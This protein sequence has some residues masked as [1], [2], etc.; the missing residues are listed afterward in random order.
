MT[1]GDRKPDHIAIVGCGFA[2]T[3]AFFQLVDEYPVRE[4]TIFEAS[5]D[6]GPGYP[7]R[8][9]ESPAYLINNTTD[10]MCL[11]P[12]NR[13]AFLQWLRTRPDIAPEVDE[14]GHLPRA[15][16]GLFLRDVVASARTAAAVKGITV[17][18]V[19]AEATG[20]SED[21][22]GRVTLSW[23]GGEVTADAAILTTG[24]CPDRDGFEHPNGEM[25]ARYYPTHIPGDVLDDV[26]LDATCHVLGA[27][28][29]AYDVINK[30]FAPDTGCEFERDESGVLRFVTGGNERHVVL[31]SRSGRLKKMESPV[32]P[33]LSRLHFTQQAIDTMSGS[34]SA[35]LRNLAALVDKDADEN[36]VVID[37]DEIANPYAEC[38]SEAADTERA[39]SLLERDIAAARADGLD[40]FLVDY[41]KDAQPTIWR[42]FAS[43][44]LSLQEEQTYRSRYETA[45][46]C[47][48][49]ALS[50]HHGRADPGVDP[51]GPSVD[52][53]RSFHGEAESGRRPATTLSTPT[54]RPRRVWLS[55]PRGRST[56][57]STATRSRR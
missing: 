6:F 53:A 45:M 8:P 1:P 7:Y 35:T 51:S 23:D 26:P 2:G 54:A 19:P 37:W 50:D 22:G 30:L 25:T 32:A 36:G 18:M 56:A 20:I 46:L 17:R 42:G 34:H 43:G 31:C 12:T 3:S 47:Y 55:T 15:V 13:R 27:S 28:L 57:K 16:F 4:I 10:T 48:A 41:V 40:N 44:A 9:D 38:E 5:G 33:A 24:R 14:K 49:G 39:A 52:S 11:T 29:S 21:A